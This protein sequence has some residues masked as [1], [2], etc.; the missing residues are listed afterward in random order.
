[1]AKIRASQSGGGGADLTLVAHADHDGNKTLTKTFVAPTSGYYYIFTCSSSYS[2]DYGGTCTI[3]K[4]GTTIPSS[5]YLYDEEK[6]NVNSAHLAKIYCNA[7][8][9]LVITASGLGSGYYGNCILILG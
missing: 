8:D 7:G 9:T 3:T 2:G 4:N 1:M 6:L 5:E